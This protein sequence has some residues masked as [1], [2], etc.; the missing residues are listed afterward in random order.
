MIISIIR[1]DKVSPR[2]QPLFFVVK[3]GSNTRRI[4]EVDDAF[5]GIRY[6]N[7]YLLRFIFYYNINMSPSL[8]RIECI[9]Q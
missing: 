4:M 3:P 2:P 9:F 6:I 7:N 8:H 1:L 5:A